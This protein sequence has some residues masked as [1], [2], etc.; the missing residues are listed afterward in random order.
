MKKTL[1]ISLLIGSMTQIF[2]QDF[3]SY[4]PAELKNA[5]SADGVNIKHIAP[6]K[7]ITFEE[8]GE[9]DS[10]YFK[11]DGKLKA[12]SGKNYSY[13]IASDKVIKKDGG[14]IVSKD[15]PT[16]D[17]INKLKI[18]LEKALSLLKK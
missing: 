2:G 13:E 4:N 5:H 3:A 7:M 18:K 17:F 11:A 14:A 10:F 15:K 1:F 6:A 9:K 12:I 16:P 8:N